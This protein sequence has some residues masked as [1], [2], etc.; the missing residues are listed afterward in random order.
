MANGADADA[1]ESH[2]SNC[3]WVRIGDIVRVF[4]HGVDVNGLL[5]ADSDGLWTQAVT[6]GCGVGASRPAGGI[7]G[8]IVCVPDVTL[9]GHGVPG[10]QNVPALWV[11]KTFE[12]KSVGVPDVM[13]VLFS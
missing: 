8:E 7:W 9:K 6:V 12:K 1:P 5:F 4:L 10:V 3:Q 2:G 11:C 13:G